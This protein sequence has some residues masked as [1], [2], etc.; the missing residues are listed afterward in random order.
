MNVP[1]TEMKPKVHKIIEIVVLLR[2]TY[3]INI[4]IKPNSKLTFDIL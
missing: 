2:G 3:V 1:T 4:N